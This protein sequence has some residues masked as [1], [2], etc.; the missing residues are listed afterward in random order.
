MAIAFLSLLLFA[1]T[2]RSYGNDQSS[3]LAFYIGFTGPFEKDGIKFYDHLVA[4]KQEFYSINNF[5][6]SFLPGTRLQITGMSV[7]G[8]LELD[9]VDW[10][11][12]DH[13]EFGR[14]L[15]CKAAPEPKEGFFTAE[16][17]RQ[18]GSSN[19]SGEDR[20]TGRPSEAKLQSWPLYKDEIARISGIAA[21]RKLGYKGAGVTIAVIDGG[22][23]PLHEQFTNKVDG[24]SRILDVFSFNGQS[25][26][27]VGSQGTFQH[28]TLVAGI[29]AGVDGGAPEAEL[30][31]YD[32]MEDMTGTPLTGRIWNALQ[33]SLRHGA[34]IVH[35]AVGT[36]TGWRN[37]AIDQLITRAALKNV[38]VIAAASNDGVF[39]FGTLNQVAT[40]EHSVT[41]GNFFQTFEPGFEMKIISKDKTISTIPYIR[42]G[43]PPVKTVYSLHNEI[44]TYETTGYRGFRPRY[45]QKS[46]PSNAAALFSC[47]GVDE[48]SCL[49][50]IN[51]TAALGVKAAFVYPPP[52][53]NHNTNK[54][55]IVGGFVSQADFLAVKELLSN[56]D[57]TIEVNPA[58]PKSVVAVPNP[59]KPNNLISP[60]SGH[61]PTC[62]MH[63]AVNVL[64]PGY[65]IVGPQGDVYRPDDGT[66]VA[67][68]QIAALAALWYEKHGR[69]RA[70]FL[71]RSLIS[72]TGRLLE[73]DNKPS[74]P[75]Y[76]GL[77]A[78][79]KQAGGM[80]NGVSVVAGRLHFYPY[81]LELLDQQRFRNT[82]KID[83]TNIG[84]AALQIEITHVEGPGAYMLEEASETGYYRVTEEPCLISSLKATVTPGSDSVVVAPGETI[85]VKFHFTR[86]ELTFDLSQRLP[87]Y[88]GWLRFSV[89][90]EEPY[91]VAY[92]GIGAAIRDIKLLASTP[93]L[94]DRASGKLITDHTKIAIGGVAK[95]KLSVRHVLGSADARVE[96]IPVVQGKILLKSPIVILR[97]IDNHRLIGL[98]KSNLLFDAVGINGAY[99]EGPENQEVT[100]VIEPGLY[101]VRVR[102][103]KL[104]ENPEVASSWEA[105]FSPILDFFEQQ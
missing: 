73:T 17:D 29:A 22:M 5:T 99:D 28:G 10:A 71:F 72:T 18:A 76:Q 41:V 84:T 4:S 34:D 105:W 30:L 40:A 3:T 13:H 89:P 87:V 67:S 25:E 36:G 33:R 47:V 63:L 50:R 88:G 80:A 24:K 19:L 37:P 35:I 98:K 48:R 69:R 26:T 86:P 94:T 12:V 101:F 14:D 93:E 79:W 9:V 81:Q 96:Y 6:G 85:S 27:V 58:T 66:S 68:P 103:L 59:Q 60:L 21:L 62:D 44:M 52:L 61:G 43:T 54:E 77:E 65:Q 75:P 53:I 45:Y 16:N 2:A 20:K 23:D 42:G 57:V 91:H 46:L 70:G 83:L 102:L 64:A 32:V 11:V 56:G 38:V 74:C 78:S 104:G 8:I 31:L 82:H 100:K 95:V 1:T 92:M 15:I 49:V 90:D 39:G 51:S 97:K 7:E 55:Q